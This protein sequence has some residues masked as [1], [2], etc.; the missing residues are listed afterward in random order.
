MAE[1]YVA[2]ERTATGRHIIQA[3]HEFRGLRTAEHY[4]TVPLTH[5]ADVPD[6][7][8]TVFAREY[9]STD[10][11]ADEAAK[12]PWLLF[13]QGGGPAAGGAIV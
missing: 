7:T 9:S 2:D 4:F 5:Q 12:L 3:R 11:S 13:L 10:H 8:I 1:P 6:E